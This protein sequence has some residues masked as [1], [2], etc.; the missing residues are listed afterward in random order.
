MINSSKEKKG[1]QRQH[2][3]RSAK[4]QSTRSEQGDAVFDNRECI[5]EGMA[6]GFDDSRNGGMWVFVGLQKVFGTVCS[7][8]THLHTPP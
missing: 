7:K 8:G 6:L 3:Q 5:E 2:H 4:R 1:R